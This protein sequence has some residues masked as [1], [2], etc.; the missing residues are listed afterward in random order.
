MNAL[1][2]KPTLVMIIVFVFTLAEKLSGLIYILEW[3]R[4]NLEPFIYLGFG[5]DPFVKKNC[6]WQNCYLVADHS[7]FNNTLDYDVLLFNA[8]ELRFPN[9]RFPL[10]RSEV[11]QYVLVGLEPSAHCPIPESFNNF[12]NLTWTYKL[13][14]DVPYPY[15]AVRNNH[16]ELIGPKTDMKWID[17]NEMLPTSEDILSILKGKSIAAAWIATNCKTI[18]NRFE[19]AVNLSSALSQYGHQVDFYGACGNHFCE[20]IPGYRNGDISGCSDKIKSDYYFYFAF[21]NSFCEDYVT[22]KVLHGLKNFAVP[23][24][25]GGANYSRYTFLIIINAI[26]IYSS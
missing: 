20:K 5:Q 9:F 13:N 14:S 8:L 16:S 6:I 25:Y 26:I 12:F 23:V 21:E 10:N 24:V 19:F 15:I 2:L 3:T 18:N 7:Y 22:E 17:I 11:Q 4:S 1:V